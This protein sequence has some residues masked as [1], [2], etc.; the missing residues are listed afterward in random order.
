MNIADPW[1][2][3]ERNIYGSTALLLYSTRYQFLYLV[4]GNALYQQC[5]IAQYQQ[6]SYRDP[7][8]NKQK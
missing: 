5:H 4:N 1:T 2:G 7:S 6:V 8:V 3:S